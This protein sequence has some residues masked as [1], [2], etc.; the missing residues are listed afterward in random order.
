MA[1]KAQREAAIKTAVEQVFQDKSGFLRRGKKA[2][3]M[4]PQPGGREGP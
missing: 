1:T 3:A 4:K 2:V